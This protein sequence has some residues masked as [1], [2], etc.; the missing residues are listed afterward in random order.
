M[1]ML[2]ALNDLVPKKDIVVFSSFPDYS[3]NSR[4]LFEHISRRHRDLLKRFDFVWLVSDYSKANEIEELGGKVLLKKSLRGLWSSLRAKYIIHTHGFWGGRIHRKSRDQSIVNLW[5]GCGYKDIAPDERTYLGDV[6]TVTGCP[7]V[8]I[9]AD[10]FGIP[11]D[12]VYPVGLPRNDCLFENGISLH[13]LGIDPSLYK[14]VIMWMPTY[15]K[16]AFGHDSIDGSE[17]SFGIGSIS[18]DEYEIINRSLQENEILLVIKPHPMD[19]VDLS[20]MADLENIR[21]LTNEDLE[22]AS[23]RLYQLLAKTDGLISDYSSVVIDYLLLNKPVAFALSDIDEY[24][25]SRGFIFSPVCDYFP[26]PVIK[27]AEELIRYFDELEETNRRWTAKREELL[28]FF[29]NHVDGDSSERVCNLL[30]REEREIDE[31]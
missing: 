30:F 6:N 4:A 5:H 14:K 18:R 17:S 19:S 31:R 29:H 23:I 16:A 3:D 2:Q 22:K 9:H 20:E 25:S 27:N 12:S 8:P 10:I 15:R 21:V 26:G 7:Y 11:Q 28:H 1:S 13:R 24:E